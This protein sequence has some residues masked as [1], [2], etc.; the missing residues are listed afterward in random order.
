MQG[1]FWR[2]K[3]ELGLLWQRFNDSSGRRLLRLLQLASSLLFVILY[4]WSTYSTPAPFSIRANIDLVLCGVFAVEYLVRYVV[5]H[6][7][8]WLRSC[9]SARLCMLATCAAMLAHEHCCG[10]EKDMR[11]AIQFASM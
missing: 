6:Q 10:Q 11:F 2:L 3:L 7:P 4:V 5:S 8:A 9:S 1:I